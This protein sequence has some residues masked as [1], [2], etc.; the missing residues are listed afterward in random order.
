MRYK[1]ASHSGSMFVKD[2]KFCIK[3]SSDLCQNARLLITHK[4]VYTIR[5]VMLFSDYDICKYC[6]FW[7]LYKHYEI[8]ITTHPAILIIYTIYTLIFE[9]NRFENCL[10]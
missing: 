2:R 6:H 7:Y 1:N 8:D 9:H 5:A 4:F 3:I 10:Y